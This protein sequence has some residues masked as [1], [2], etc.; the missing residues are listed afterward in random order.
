MTFMALNKSL[1]SCTHKNGCDFPNQR[2]WPCKTTQNTDASPAG[3]KH[4]EFSKTATE[5]SAIFL[6]F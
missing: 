4:S 6:Q 2:H 1:S 3:R 5:K